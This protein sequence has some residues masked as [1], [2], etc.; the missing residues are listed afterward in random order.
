MFTDSMPTHD[1]R[2]RER[3]ALRRQSILWLA[4]LSSGEMTAADSEAFRRWCDECPAHAAAFAEA[5]VLWKVLAPAAQRVAALDPVGRVAPDLMTPSRATMARRGFIGGAAAAAVAG[6]GYLVVRPPLDLWPSVSELAAQ[7]R[8]T[9]G[10]RRQLAIA[11]GGAVDMNTRTSLNIGAT[12]GGADRIDLI[13]GEAV[14]RTADDRAQQVV[15]VAGPGRASAS[16]AKFDVR[17]DGLAACVTC[18]DG[19]VKVEHREAGAVIRQRQQIVYDSAGL[20]QVTVVDPS[21]VTSW[22]TGMLIFRSEPMAR[23]IEEI[24][25]YRRGR[26]VIV[27]A[28]LG[29]KR[30]DASFRLDRIDEIVPQIEM[31]F[32]TRA[33]AFP[34]GIVLLG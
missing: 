21:V 2:S 22:Q 32:G 1:D 7:Y 13:A 4:R 18:L 30:I 28:A 9:T 11:G 25:R 24:N 8:T 14:V 20:G 19:S 33:R 5:N 17:F 27:D 12:P 10:E 15:V 29:R 34:G 3:E 31:V 16:S 23:A 6:A 26:I